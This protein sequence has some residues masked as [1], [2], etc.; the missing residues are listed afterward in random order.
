[1]SNDTAIVVQQLIYD[2][3]PFPNTGT[4]Y[5][6][7]EPHLLVSQEVLCLYIEVDLPCQS[8]NDQHLQRVDVSIRTISRRHLV[9]QQTQ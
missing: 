1:M 9:H 2:D 3:V 8:S 5:G 7:E 4:E 6:R